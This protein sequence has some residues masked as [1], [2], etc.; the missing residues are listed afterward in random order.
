MMD[1]SFY[2]FKVYINKNLTVF[3]VIIHPYRFFFQFLLTFFNKWFSFKFFVIFLSFLFFP[4]SMFP[5]MIIAMIIS[6]H[7]LD[8]RIIF[9]FIS[10]LTC[11]FPF[12]KCFFLSFSFMLI[13]FLFSFLSFLLDIFCFFHGIILLSFFQFPFF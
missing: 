8:V 3:Y 13:Y 10:S 1:L 5:F 4:V 9:A 2:Q 6:T 7:T 12:R 11:L